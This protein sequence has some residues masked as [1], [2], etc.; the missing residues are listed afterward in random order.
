MEE[1]HYWVQAAPF[2]ALLQHLS[3]SNGLPWAVVAKR[4]KLPLPLA[5]SLLFGRGGKPLARIPPDLARQ[6]LDLERNLRPKA[7][8]IRRAA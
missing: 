8:R 1:D 5:H 4:A 6:L 2:R 7:A 3:E